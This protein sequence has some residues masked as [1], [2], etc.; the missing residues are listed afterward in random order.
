MGVQDPSIPV[1]YLEPYDVEA[2]RQAYAQEKVVLI[3][4]GTGEDNKTTD[5]AV[6]E[7]ARRH[8]EHDPAAELLVLKGTKEE[9]VFHG[10]PRKVANAQRY[11][12]ITAG[13]MLADYERFSVVDRACLEQIHETGIPMRIYADGQHDLSAAVSADNGNVGT[14]VT[15][16]SA[17]PVFAD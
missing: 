12:S 1:G 16:G 2:V 5:N 11:A 4:G 6:M 7:Y 15:G 9:G 14:L 13:Y 8:H 10:D 3:A 17:S